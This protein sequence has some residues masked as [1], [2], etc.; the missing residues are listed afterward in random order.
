MGGAIA[1]QGSK[2]QEESQKI[3]VQQGKVAKT[4]RTIEAL[5]E[6]VQANV[7][8]EA[9]AKSTIAQDKHATSAV[10]KAEV[11]KMAKEQSDKQKDASAK[12]MEQSQG[13]SM[14]SARMARRARRANQHCAQRARARRGGARQDVADS[15]AAV[16][17]WWPHV[18]RTALK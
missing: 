9:T 14:K 2:L 8:L 10:K 16:L 6:Q 11:E 5:K 17:W 15:H 13:K 4:E 18:F 12:Q 7:A 1:E 3:Q